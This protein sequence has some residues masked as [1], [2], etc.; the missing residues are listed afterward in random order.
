M[1]TD[2][3]NR[4]TLSVDEAMSALGLG[5]TMFYELLGDGSIRSFKC[6]K[7]RL[8]IVESLRQWITD[9]ESYNIGNLSK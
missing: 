5:K 1:S 9:M 8:V 4:L 3:K 2:L 6:G 7:K